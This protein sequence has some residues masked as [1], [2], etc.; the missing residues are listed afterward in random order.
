MPIFS[1]KCNV[2]ST[3]FEM[4]VTKNKEI[5]CPACNTNNITKIPSSFNF[6]VKGYNERN[7]YSKKD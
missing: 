5:R 6:K 7:G 3:E 2:C 4:I 1:F